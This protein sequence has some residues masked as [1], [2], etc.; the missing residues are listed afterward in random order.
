M[1][2]KSRLAV[3]LTA[4]V[5]GAVF[6]AVLAIL[7]STTSSAQSPSTQLIYGQNSGTLKAVSTDSSGRLTIAA[8]ADPCMDPNVAKSSVSVNIA[9]ATTTQI[10]AIS[11]TTTVYV[12]G[13][14]FTA[15]GTNPTYQFEYGTGA[16][17]GSG[18][19]VLTGTFLPVV[20]SVNSVFGAGTI[21]K[22]AAA[23]AV[24]IVSGGTPSIQGAVTFV[25]Q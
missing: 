20:S 2:T 3:R 24:C 23:N 9:S 6:G 25:Q 21:I 15:A 10:V 19:T 11:G 17:C 4:T 18:T 5:V 1:G 13:W 16:S 7:L 14:V 22:G 12:C 8:S